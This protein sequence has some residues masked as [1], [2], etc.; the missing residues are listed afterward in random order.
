VEALVPRSLEVWDDKG[1]T[2]LLS[3]RNEAQAMS[4]AGRFERAAELYQLVL[5]GRLE[6]LGPKAASTMVAMNSIAVLRMR[7]GES[8]AAAPLVKTAELLL[9]DERAPA[10]LKRS[11]V[12]EVIEL[13]E[14]CGNPNEVAR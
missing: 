12:D 9:A 6:M 4:V 2:T 3:V 8:A 10:R 5:A 11:A 14:T 1:A 7:Q 13:Y